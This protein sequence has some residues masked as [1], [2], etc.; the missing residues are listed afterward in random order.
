MRSLSP[1]RTLTCTR[2]VSPDL[3]AGRSAS[4]EFSTSSIAPIPHPHLEM[5]ELQDGRIAES[6]ALRLATFDLPFL[7]SCNS[8]ILQFSK[9]P[10]FFI[11]QSRRCQ[12]I[13]PTRQRSRQRFPL[14]PTTDLRVIARQQ[15]VRHLEIRTLLLARPKRDFC[16]PRVL[17][18]IQ[19][20]ATER[21]VRYRLLV[22]N[23][24]RQQACQRVDDD[25]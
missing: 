4:C 22:A 16:R 11:V 1:S 19:Q 7:Q 14:P 2:T 21:V 3:I 15:H 12:Q 18:E 25:Q 10:S 20:P 17:R 5:A 13:R 8:A 23:D 9:Y 24:P 6:P